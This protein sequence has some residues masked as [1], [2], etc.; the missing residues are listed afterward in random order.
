MRHGKHTGIGWAWE[1]QDIEGNWVLCNWAEPYKEML[2]ND[3]HS[4]PADG[5]R[6][7]RVEL[8]PTSK[9]N[10]KRYGITA[11]DRHAPKEEK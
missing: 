9:R 6:L 10:R 3:E 2:L 1:F 11:L 7:I 5:C 4:K 8:V